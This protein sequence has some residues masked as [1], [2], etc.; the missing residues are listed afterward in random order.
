METWRPRRL[1]D[2]RPANAEDPR[3]TGF[4]PGLGR[5]PE[6]GVALAPVF[7]PGKFHGQRSVAGYSPWGCKELDQAECIHMQARVRARA[8][9]HTH[10][11]T[12]TQ[13]NRSRQE[14][15][16]SL[17]LLEVLANKQ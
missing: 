9:T 12:H 15:L 14:Q 16:Q 4:I 13:K 6:K 17:F 10:T 11:H 2:N 7:L 5:S 1:S 3:D 8:H